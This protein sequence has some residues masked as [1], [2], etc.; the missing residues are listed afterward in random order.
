MWVQFPPVAPI[1]TY[2]IRGKDYWIYVDNFN[3]IGRFRYINNNWI[4]TSSVP[5]RALTVKE[6]LQLSM[7]LQTL[8][9][10][11]RL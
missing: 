2:I 9:V 1:M 4:Y 11:G 6:L 10:V 5:G 7:D 3:Y 8:N